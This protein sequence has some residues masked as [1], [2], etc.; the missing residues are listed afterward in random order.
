MAVGFPLLSVKS[1]LPLHAEEM[2]SFC[3][4]GALSQI[5]LTSPPLAAVARARRLSMAS[6]PPPLPSSSPS[7]LLRLS[8]ASLCDHFCLFSDAAKLIPLEEGSEDRVSSWCSG[9]GVRSRTR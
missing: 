8:C 1:T 7:F 3:D 6:A 5:T 9:R 2:T 4:A